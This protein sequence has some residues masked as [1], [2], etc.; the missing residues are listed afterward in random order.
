MVNLYK[1]EF[2][3]GRGIGC[4]S[5]KDIKIGT[6]ILQEKPVCAVLNLSPNYLGENDISAILKSFESMTDYNQK[7]YLK[8]YN[9][10]EDWNTLNEEDKKKVDHKKQILED[11]QTDPDDMKKCQTILGKFFLENVWPIRCK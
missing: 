5:Q 10:F 2:I 3:E 1:T 4:I 11:L 9:R 6:L 8:L 7:E